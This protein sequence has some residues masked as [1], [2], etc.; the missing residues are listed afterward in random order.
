MSFAMKRAIDVLD[1]RIDP[2]GGPVGLFLGAGINDAIEC[3]VDRHLV[4][5]L[6]HC[7]FQAARN[8]EPPEWQDTALGW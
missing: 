5:H 4:R 2:G 6:P 7:P 8:M 1:L 3:G